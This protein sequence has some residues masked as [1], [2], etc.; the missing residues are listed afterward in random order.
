M[1]HR[2]AAEF[3]GTT[4]LVLVG[5]GSSLLAPADASLFLRVM[6]T[7]SAFGLAA[8]ALGLATRQHSG[9]HLNPAITVG[10]CVA[11]RFPRAQVLP[12]LGAQVAGAL[13]AMTLL[14][15]VASGGPAYAPESLA[16]NG[17]GAHS[18]AG[19]SLWSCLVAEISLTCMVVFAVL[20]AGGRGAT[21]VAVPIAG[22]MALAAAH[23][24]GVPLT[25]GSFN[26]ARS[27][28]PALFAGGWAFQQL[29]LFWVAPLAGA[30]LAGLTYAA[31]RE[32]PRSAPHE[33]RSP[34]GAGRVSTP[35]PV[36]DTAPRSSREAG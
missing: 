20:G 35:G 8:L 17:Y 30:A 33:A 11:G 29:W 27:T 23:L 26:P 16:A 10:L 21:G 32:A 7:A 3:F 1:H 25:G 22:A 24:V 12:Y 28:G 18:P 2:P 5:C 34:F 36:H 4:W 6:V 14:N 9:G 15:I 13:L 31:L 19:Y